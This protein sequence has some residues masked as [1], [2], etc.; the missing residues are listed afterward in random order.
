MSNSTK[1]QDVVIAL[2]QAKVDMTR[3]I[4]AD[5]PNTKL[6]GVYKIID[7]LAEKVVEATL[8]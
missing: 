2:T 5:I 4:G 3:L 7:T 8:S 1:I 6:E